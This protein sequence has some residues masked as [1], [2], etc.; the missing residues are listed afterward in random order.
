M[1]KA[2][3]H[4]IRYGVILIDQYATLSRD[5]YE[6][7][8]TVWKL[9]KQ[10]AMLIFTGDFRQLAPFADDVG[11]LPNA[12]ASSYFAM[13]RVRTLT[14]AMGSQDLQLSRVLG[15][16][17]FFPPDVRTFN[18]LRRRAV[19]EDCSYHSLASTLIRYPN[20]VFVAISKAAVAVVNKWCCT[21]L[22]S[23]VPLACLQ[24]EHDEIALHKGARLMITRNLNKEAGVC[25]GTFGKV[26]GFQRDLIFVDIDGTEHVVHKWTDD[27]CTGSFYPVVLGYA[28]TLAKDTGV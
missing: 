20:T 11:V 15:R 9:T 13:M 2:A 3:D 21:Y 27:R 8:W 25:N 23:G 1:T 26:I 19:A 14:V 18:A 4:I 12:R 6:H 28:T 10:F 22:F 7:I 5:Q 16:L 17:R 24:C